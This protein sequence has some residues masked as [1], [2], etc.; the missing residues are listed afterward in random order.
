MILSIPNHLLYG[1]NCD[2]K[3]FCGTAKC[4]GYIGGDISGS[5]I[6]TQHDAEAE[7]FEPMVTYKDA[8]EMLGNACSHDANPSVV[9]LE[10]ETSIQLEDS[11]NCIPVTPDSEPHQ[12]SPILFDNSEL[13]NSWEMWSPQDAEDPTRTPVHVPR[14]IDSTLQQLPVYDTQP[15]EFLPKAP[16]T[17]DGPK[18][19]N[20]MN[21]SARSSDLGHNL[22]VPGFHAKK[23]NN[24][25][26]HRDVKSSSCS[27]DNENTLG[28]NTCC[29]MFFSCCLA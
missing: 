8:V 16:N 14:T 25:K 28:G 26:D 15:L 11:N 6:S 22:V 12:T 23:K 17:M 27:T 21:R 13:E 24:L 5:G 9:E 7:Y 18:A 1:F 10:H 4:R 19:P 29:Q 2:Q 20:V 3:C